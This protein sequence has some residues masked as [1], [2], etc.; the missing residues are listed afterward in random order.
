[1]R[2]NLDVSMQ[3]IGRRA[4]IFNPEIDFYSLNRIA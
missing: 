1:M 3:I 4:G 2:S